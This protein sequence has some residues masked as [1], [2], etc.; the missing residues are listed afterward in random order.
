[1]NNQMTKDGRFQKY[2]SSANH[3]IKNH[4]AVRRWAAVNGRDNGD[5][6]NP[7]LIQDNSTPGF[8]SHLSFV[9]I[10]FSTLTITTH[11]HHAS[12]KCTR[13]T[14]PDRV[15]RALQKP[16]HRNCC[17]HPRSTCCGQNNNY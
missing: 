16:P 7:I 10:L 5:S 1:M 6:E 2:S 17:P 4:A 14:C 12:L 3:R 13:C 8:R 15:F 11:C 9:L